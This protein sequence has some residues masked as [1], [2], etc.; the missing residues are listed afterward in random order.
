[1]IPDAPPVSSVPVGLFEVDARTRF[2]GFSARA[3]LAMLFIGDTAKLNQALAANEPGADLPIAPRSQGGYL[4]AAYDLLRLLAPSTDQSVTLFARYDYV[5]TQASVAQASIDAGFVPNNAFIRH[6]LT[7]G[8]VYRPIP[9]IAL[10]GDYRRH[11]LG[12]GP[13]FNE[14]AAGLGWMF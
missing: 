10:K 4:E 12:V 5:N 6:I 14:W 13:G 3:E 1:M 7:A 11:E 8:L 9:Q 2:R